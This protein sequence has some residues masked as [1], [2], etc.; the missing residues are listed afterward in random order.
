[1]G[2]VKLDII[3]N[4]FFTDTNFNLIDNTIYYGKGISRNTLI[5]N[6]KIISYYLT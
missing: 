2:V 6:T 3:S 5:S 1:M 4:Y